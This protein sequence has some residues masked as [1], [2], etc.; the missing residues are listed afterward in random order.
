MDP[1]GPMPTVGRDE[2]LV[3]TVDLPHIDHSDGH[4]QAGLAG[5]LP[6]HVKVCV[7]GLILLYEAHYSSF[8]SHDNSLEYKLIRCR[9]WRVLKETQPSAKGESGILH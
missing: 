3:V 5:I 1:H 4:L 7:S 6:G 9:A 8:N 2:Q